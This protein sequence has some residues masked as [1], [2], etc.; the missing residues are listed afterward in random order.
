[1]SDRQPPPM[2]RSD[3]RSTG[4]YV[5][6]EPIAPLPPPRSEAG[7]FGWMRQNLFSVAVEHRAHDRFRAAARLDRAAARQAS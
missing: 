6:K 3:V 5:R 7:A 2:Q 1:M 4:A